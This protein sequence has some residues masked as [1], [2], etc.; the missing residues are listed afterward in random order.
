LVNHKDGLTQEN[1]IV[2]DTKPG[3]SDISRKANTYL[4]RSRFTHW[5]GDCDVGDR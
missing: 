5:S 1:T 4:D 2:I 3:T